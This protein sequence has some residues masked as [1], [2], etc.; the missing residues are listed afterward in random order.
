VTKS[1]DV[2][3]PMP[4]WVLVHSFRYALGRSTY[5]NCDAAALTRRYWN[6]LPAFIQEQFRED[7]HRVDWDGPMKVASDRS[8]W[9]FMFDEVDGGTDG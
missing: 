3:V 9:M 4:L 5:A 6:N 1:L 7:F 2:E 8:C